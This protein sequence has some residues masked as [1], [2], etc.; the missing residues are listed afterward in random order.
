MIV[1]LIRV[2][3]FLLLVTV[4]HFYDERITLSLIYFGSL[5]I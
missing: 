1:I 5:I 2:K 4:P 3:M